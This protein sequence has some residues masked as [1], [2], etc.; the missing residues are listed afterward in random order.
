VGG[1]DVV[2]IPRLELFDAAYSSLEEDY[3]SAVARSV[4]RLGKS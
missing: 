4:A 2:V 3:R 1:I